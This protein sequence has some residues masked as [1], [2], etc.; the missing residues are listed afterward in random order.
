M[1]YE[2]PSFNGEWLFLAA[3][4]LHLWHRS[5]PP[6]RV[7]LRERICLPPSTPSPLS[8]RLSSTGLKSPATSPHPSKQVVQECLPVVHH[9][10]LAASAKARLTRRGLTLRRNPQ[11]YGEAGSHGFDATHASILTGRLSSSACRVDLRPASHAPLPI[12]SPVSVL[13]LAPLNCPRRR[14]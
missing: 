11:T 4:P 14:V 9:L 10:R 12:A 7:Q 8:T 6:S 13:G 5:A 1:R 3:G 2:H